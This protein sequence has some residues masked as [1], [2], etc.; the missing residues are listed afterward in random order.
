MLVFARKAAQGQKSALNLL[1]GRVHTKK[2]EQ[3]LLVDLIP[4]IKNIQGGFIQIKDLGITRR[5]DNASMVQ[6]YIKGN[7]KTELENKRNEEA[8]RKSLLPIPK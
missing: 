3:K 7:E 2:I 6:I 4:R 1:K 8:K 5:G